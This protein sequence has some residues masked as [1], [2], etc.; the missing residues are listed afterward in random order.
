MFG[1][2]MVR[3][4]SD[5]EWWYKMATILAKNGGHFIWMLNGP[6]IRTNL[7]LFKYEEK[8]YLWRGHFE[9]FCF[10][11]VVW[12]P[13]HSKTKFK[14]FGL[15]MDLVRAFSIRAPTV[16]WYEVMRRLLKK[17]FQSH[18]VSPPW[19]HL[20]PLDFRVRSFWGLIWRLWWLLRS[21]IPEIFY[22]PLE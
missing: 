12:T 15:Q 16:Y 11:M 10:W 18:F 1:F 13:S 19:V 22:S 20:H 17:Y 2:R 6:E 14:R 21:R 3:V 4:C 8:S 7:D 5:F 9:L